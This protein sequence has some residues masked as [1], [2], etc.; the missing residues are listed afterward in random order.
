MTLDPVVLHTL[1]VSDIT[2]ARSQKARAL[3]QQHAER[4]AHGKFKRPP[5]VPTDRTEA[6]PRPARTG[7]L[8]Q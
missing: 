8:R 6:R 2:V 5:K 3:R 7:R 1:P 4:V